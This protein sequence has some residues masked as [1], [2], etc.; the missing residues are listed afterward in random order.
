MN[1][2]QWLLDRAEYPDYLAWARDHVV[3]DTSSE[4]SLRDIERAY[5]AAVSCEDP[6]WKGYVAKCMR[7]MGIGGSRLRGYHCR[8]V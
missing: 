3:V 7:W 4:T 8:I 1:K 2:Y 6:P 5:M